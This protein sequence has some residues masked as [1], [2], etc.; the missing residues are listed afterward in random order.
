MPFDADATTGGAA[1]A[2]LR[3]IECDGRDNVEAVFWFAG[4]VYSHISGEADRVLFAV[5]G[6]L[7]RSTVSIAD[8]VRGQGFARVG[9]E[10][11]LYKDVATGAVLHHWDNPFTGVRN[12]VVQVA[13]DHVNAR[14][15]ERGADGLPFAIPVRVGGGH[16][17]MAQQIPIRRANP[18]GAGY[19]S[20][21]G[22]AYHAVELFSFS[23]A[24]S[25]VADQALTSLPVSVTWSRL[26]DWLPFMEMGGRAGRI[27]AHVTG[28]KLQEGGVLPD[29][30]A[31]IIDREYPAFRQPPPSNDAA[32]MDTSWTEYRRI[33]ETGHRWFKPS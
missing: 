19:D 26:S 33:K 24:E 27:Y 1:V 22:A 2:L 3:R 30:F 9:R 12:D 8:P 29:A 6:M 4:K 5:E 10:M 16:W 15:Y 14:Y 21:I 20:E 32:V 17:Q 13:N 31:H 28:H 18:L 11:M 23:G 7:I 25:D